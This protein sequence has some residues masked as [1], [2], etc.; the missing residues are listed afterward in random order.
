L[1]IDEF[2][3]LLHLGEAPRWWDLI[4]LPYLPSEEAIKELKDGVVSVKIAQ[5]DILAD[6][7]DMW[8]ANRHKQLLP[9]Q[10]GQLYGMLRVDPAFGLKKHEGELFA[11]LASLTL[12]YTSRLLSE[13]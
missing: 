11:I 4:G 5:R 8:L 3:G 12:R 1:Q 7:L 6:G 9:N 10:P 13:K 2:Q